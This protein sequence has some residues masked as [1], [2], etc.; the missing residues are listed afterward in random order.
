MFKGAGT[1]IVT[2]FDKNQNVD[3]NSLKKITKHQVDNNI[4]A[5][6]ILGTTG[7]A[8][9]VEADERKKIIETIM[10]EAAGKCKIIIGT[11][12]NNTKKVAELNKTADEFKPDALLIANPYYNKGTQESLV[13]HYKYLSERTSTPIMLY[14]VPSRTGMNL[15]PETA[16]KIHETCKNVIA[17]KEASGSISQI[18]HLCSIKPDTFRVVSGNDDQTLPIMAVGGDGVISVFTNAFPGQMKKITDAFLAGNISEAQR[19]NKMYLEM[20]R[21]LFF[22]TSPGPL[23][24]IMSKMGLCENVF[25]LPIA[26]V[27]KNTEARLDEVFERFSKL[28]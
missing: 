24:Y 19:Y 14:N 23:K 16:I 6:I 2:P 26:P 4:D 18:A 28:N 20:M 25:R 22:E 3:Y 21:A 9:V 11:G 10:S 15:L 12:G 7:E 13:E 17:I 27:S 8:P 1:A 5:I